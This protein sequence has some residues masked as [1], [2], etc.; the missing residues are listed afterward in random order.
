MQT[1]K[2]AGA[3]RAEPVESEP[4]VAKHTAPV[5]TSAT[6]ALL[7]EIDA[8]LEA[9]SGSTD[10]GEA[11]DGVAGGFAAALYALG[12]IGDLLG[13]TN[14]NAVCPCGFPLSQCARVNGGAVVVILR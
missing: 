4:V 14:P 8:A 9:D 3:R 1:H 7:D 12:F 13:E 6:D 11:G 10:A 5:D 2:Q